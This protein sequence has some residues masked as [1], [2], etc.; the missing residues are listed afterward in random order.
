[1]NFKKPSMMKVLVATALL[2]LCLGKTLPAETST[3]NAL[4]PS[5]LTEVKPAER[6]KALASSAMT[7]SALTEVKSAERSKADLQDPTAKTKREI[8]KV[9]IGRSPG[10]FQREAQKQ[11]GVFLARNA[12]LGLATDVPETFDTVE[13]AQ[14]SPAEGEETEEALIEQETAEAELGENGA[15]IK[16]TA[17]TEDA[18]HGQHDKSLAEAV[19]IS[20]AEEDSAKRGCFCQPSGWCSEGCDH[21]IRI[22][23]VDKDDCE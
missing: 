18:S 12:A 4:T 7:P 19:N 13:P 3:S 2:S 15:S 8:K 17:M 9:L 14:P 23:C 20:V 11:L 21:G 22:D 6:S 16:A 10:G 1:M 5:A